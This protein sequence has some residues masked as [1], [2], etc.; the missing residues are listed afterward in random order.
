MD[1]ILA[2]DN[3]G[4]APDGW[5]SHLI[6]PWDQFETAIGQYRLDLVERDLARRTRSCHLQLAIS[7]YDKASGAP[8]DRTPRMYKRSLRLNVGGRTGE[9][10]PYDAVWTAAYCRAVDALADRFRDHP[11]VT[12][13]WCTP[14]WNQE[15]QAAVATASGDWATAARQVLVESVYYNFLLA[16]TRSA[17][18]AW[19]EMPVWLPGA[20]DPGAVWGHKRRDLIKTLLNEGACYLNCGLQVDN[21]N[22]NGIGE[23][24]GTAIYDIAAGDRVRAFEEGR[25][26]AA[27]E[28]M[29]LYWMLLRARHW[30]ARFVNLYGSISA[31]DYV[32][33]AGYLPAADARWIVF[34]DLEYPPQTFSANGKLYGYSGEPGCWGVG[35]KVEGAAPVFNAASYGF[36]RWQWTPTEAFTLRLPGLR[37]GNYSAT[38][39]APNGM[40]KMQTVAVQNEKTTILPGSYHRIDIGARLLTLEERVSALE[41][42]RDSLIT[43]QGGQEV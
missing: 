35:I 21:S 1:M 7:I 13:Y 38:L 9:I 8:V 31:P 42:W 10:P 14:G 26:F 20:P 2:W 5:G 3:L 30:N 22:S 28:P 6:Y 17:L 40:Q 23:R 43:P 36:D 25:R 32:Q 11:Q 41:A 27:Q 16:S 39:W 29:E 33:V 24:A 4:K 12:G 15:T 18:V 19:G 37:D 34:R